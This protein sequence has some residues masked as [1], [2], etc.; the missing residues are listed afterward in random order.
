MP[1]PAAEQDILLRGAKLMELGLP[2]IHAAQALIQANVAAFEVQHSR[3]KNAAVQEAVSKFKESLHRVATNR[4]HLCCV[5]WSLTFADHFAFSLHIRGEIDTK[6]LFPP[7]IFEE[8]LDWGH[9]HHH[10]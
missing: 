6:H 5:F 9:D 2:D 1:R 3:C 10:I 4:K 7:F 8:G